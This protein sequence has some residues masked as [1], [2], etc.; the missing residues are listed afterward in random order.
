LKKKLELEIEL[1]LLLYGISCHAKD[2]RVAWHINKILG[3]DL[4]R[5]DDLIIKITE[6]A[7]FQ[8][9]DE[10]YQVTYTLVANRSENGP[11]IPERKE[12][13]YFLLIEGAY[14]QMEENTILH[15]IKKSEII[16]AAFE[17]D[18]NSLK[19]KE[20]LIFD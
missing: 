9:F 3:L 13:D 4:K 16:L 2:Y 7:L 1:D 5:A 17:I 6:F 8:E 18:V 15:D 11:L 20:L 14:D 12:L 19:S 10:E